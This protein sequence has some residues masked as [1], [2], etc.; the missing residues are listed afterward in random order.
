MKLPTL[1]TPKYSLVVPST[2]QTIEYRPFLVKEEKI[3]MLAQE[4]G[5]AEDVTR[6]MLDIIHACTFGAVEPRDLASFDLEYIFV[7][8]RAKSVGEEVEVGI[9]CENCGSLNHVNINLEQISMT[10]ETKLPKK[11]M[12]TDNIG[13]VP[14]HISL[15]DVEKISSYQ[16]DKGKSLIMTIAASISNIFDEKGVYDVADA[17]YEEIDSFISS[18]NRQQMSKIEELIQN[19]PKFEK[20]ITFKCISCEV[21]NNQ[22]LSGMQSFFE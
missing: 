18:L 7:K 16:E 5:K 15:K 2:G 6:A 9:K 11:I 10:G 17:S 22:K 20:D 4:S 3:L 13:I 8:L 19:S 14:K 1:T 21:E 12:L